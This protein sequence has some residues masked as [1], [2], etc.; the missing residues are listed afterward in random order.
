MNK[1]LAG[2]NTA[3]LIALS[4]VSGAAPAVSADPCAT[5]TSIAITGADPQRGYDY[6]NGMANRSPLL[7]TVTAPS[8]C[9]LEGYPAGSMT[10]RNKAGDSATLPLQI[11][12]Y[13]DPAPGTVQM[14]GSLGYPNIPAGK[15]GAESVTINWASGPETYPAPSRKAWPVFTNTDRVQSWLRLP[16]IR[17]NF[18][19]GGSAPGVTVWAESRVAFATR[20]GTAVSWDFGI[21]CPKGKTY[22]LD[23]EVDQMNNPNF[24]QAS[25]E[26]YG[27]PAE[28]MATGTCTGKEMHVP[29]LLDVV[30]S[31][32]APT[33]DIIAWVSTAAAGQPMYYSS[34]GDLYVT[35]SVPSGWC[36]FPNCAGETRWPR[37]QLNG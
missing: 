3:A 10:V 33:Q 27:V 13:P 22:T 7:V 29:M 23:V 1:I 31:P 12:D 4:L 5:A 9:V 34:I 15:F 36:N 21:I 25:G 26:D 11:F 28:G 24:P 19:D 2:L 6:S 17:E 37:V 32:F 20:G 18:A 30:P 16:S 35:G 8:T 14:H